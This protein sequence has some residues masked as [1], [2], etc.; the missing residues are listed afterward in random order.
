MP[1][2]H[3]ALEAT[4][5]QE[6]ALRPHGPEIKAAFAT[7]KKSA[8]SA[9]PY[10][11]RSLLLN[12][13]FCRSRFRCGAGSSHLCRLVPLSLLNYWRIDCR[14]RLIWQTLRTNPQESKQAHVLERLQQQGSNGF[15]RSD[16]NEPFC[17]K[18]TLYR[19]VA[20]A[21]PPL[22]RVKLMPELTVSSRC[23]TPSHLFS[24]LLPLCLNFF[25][26]LSLSLSIAFS[27]CLFLPC[28]LSLSL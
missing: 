16:G 22:W 17:S 7:D 6:L 3:L 4:C 19:W 5:R 15:H 20:R 14:T 2:L 21:P 27:F 1:A 11:W 10:T 23:V 28:S 12:F 9:N 25:L 26:S 8:V 13:F 24:F 18:K